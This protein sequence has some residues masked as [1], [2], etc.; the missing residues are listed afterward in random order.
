MKNPKS[1]VNRWPRPMG[2]TALA[3]NYRKKPSDEGLNQLYLYLVSQW[4]MNNGVLCG[5][6]YD[7]NTL[8]RV[9]HI[10]PSYVKGYM[11]DTVLNSKIWDREKHEELINGLLGEQLAWAIE[12]RLE[13]LQQVDILKKSQQ[14]K[15]VPFVSAELNKAL[16]LRLE[17]SASLQ[18]IVR[19]LTGGNTTNIFTQINNHGEEGVQ[20]GITIEEAR[21]LIQESNMNNNVDDSVKQLETTYN[22]KSLPEVV[23]TKQEGNFENKEG[24][25]L[26]KVELNAITDDYKGAIEASSKEHHEQRREIEMRIDPDEEDPELDIYEEDVEDDF[27]PLYRKNPYLN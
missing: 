15:Y 27:T 8:S 13:I 26:N 10:D 24:T 25:T 18:S 4:F 11:R 21:Q 22:I 19:G 16:K 7:V 20:E 17:S 9:F 6:S 3:I 23:A 12:D 2:I 5:V 14:G 1:N